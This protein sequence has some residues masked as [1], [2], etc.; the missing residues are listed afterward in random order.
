M[1]TA[2]KS[3][4]MTLAAAFAMAAL[5]PASAMAQGGCAWYVKI[6]LKQQS[7]NMA[8]GCN[9]SGPQWSSNQ[10][11]HQKFCTSVRPII[12]KKVAQIRKTELEN[13]CKPK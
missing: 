9:K 2:R 10:Q 8:K 4:A 3:V 7:D 6:S 5:A 13:N 1:T 11:V 12:W